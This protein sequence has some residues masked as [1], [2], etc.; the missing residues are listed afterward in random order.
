[1]VSLHAEVTKIHWLVEEMPGEYLIGASARE[2]D[3]S[4]S[5]RDEDILRFMEKVDRCCTYEVTAM[6]GPFLIAKWW[7]IDNFPLTYDKREPSLR[8]RRWW[9]GYRQESVLVGERP[10]LSV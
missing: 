10:S 6:L 4:L 5:P 7:E 8:S 3:A 2:I 9:L 1:M